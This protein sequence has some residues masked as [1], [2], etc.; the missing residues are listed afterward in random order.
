MKKYI[1]ALDEGTTSARA[2]LF[3]RDSQ[4]VSMA[5]HEFTQFYPQ[6][7]WVEQDAMEIY[8]NQ[9]AALTECVAKSGISP[10][11]IAAVGIT[12]QR[13]TVVAWNKNTGKPVCR[14][15]VWQ[16]R[17]TADICK[18]LLREGHSEYI[19]NTTGLRLDPYF[20][21]TKIKWI[22]DNIDG[23]REM[24]E[25][26]E[27]M[28]GT[29][30]TWLI[31][32]LTDGEVFVTDVTNA[33]RT[34]L[35][36]I[37]TGKWDEKMLTILDIP[38]EILPEVR[39]SSEIYGSLE[40]MG[41]TIPIAGIAGDQQAALFGQGC[42]A[43]GEAKNTYGTGCFLLAHTGT[44]AVGS[45]Y[46]LL[47]TVAATEKGRPLEYAL[48]G[49]VFVG[50][51][52]IRWL[53]DE[54]KLIHDS[55]DSE[56]FARKVEDTGGIYLVPA[57][58]GL[59]APTWDM[60]ARGTILGLTAGSGKNHIIRAA[61][62]SIA[63]QTEDVLSAMKADMSAFCGLSASEAI[64][65]LRVDGGASAND[66]LM[67]MQSDISQIEVK[68]SGNPEATAAGAAYLA[69]LAVGFFDSRDEI[70]KSL[71]SGR[72]FTPEMDNGQ[73]IK[74]IEG[75]QRAVRACRAFTEG[76]E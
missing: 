28:V 22:L 31:W 36:N 4:I 60:H 62:E 6:P 7:G 9:Y 2:I 38:R 43:A 70:K 21:G 64:S 29:V 23:A 52:V 27:L 75:W 30:D 37:H 49:S 15:I 10:D 5:Q 33:S 74:R 3:D 55:K 73:R 72:A 13:E 32:K 39:S 25:R 20:S 67:Q 69:G 48:E 24:A 76:E 40:C 66:L 41:A 54:L 53:R 16:C 18:E 57:F 45:E 19:R 51:A 63:Y 12:N 26:G 44:Q 59:G 61:L 65:S 35:F 17:R 56:Y 11:E 58:S 14:A 42:F 34:M 1:L 8:A 50:G 68:R 71:A 47:T 46:G